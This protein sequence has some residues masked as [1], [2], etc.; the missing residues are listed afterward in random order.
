MEPM[1]D[2]EAPPRS[3]ARKP[4]SCSTCR[5]KKIRCD[6]RMPCCHCVKANLHCTFPAQ[7]KPRERKPHL[8]NRQPEEQDEAEA[9]G[10][11]LARRLRSLE[12]QVST[13][14]TQLVEANK[15]SSP[16]PRYELVKRTAAVHSAGAVSHIKSS[17]WASINFEVGLLPLLLST[18]HSYY[19]TLAGPSFPLQNQPDVSML[20]FKSF[21]GLRH[22]LHHPPETHIIL[23]WHVFEENV[24]PM[25]GLLHCPTMANL[26]ERALWSRHTL[27]IAE[28][29]LLFSMYYVA[30]ASM[31]EETI[32]R[33]FSVS[34]PALLSRMRVLVEQAL[35]AAKFASTVDV[36]AL[37]A[38]LLFVLVLRKTGEARSAGSLVGVIAHLAQCLRLHKD[39]AGM[40][41][42][43][44]FQQEMRRRVFW[45]VVVL[46]HRSAEDLGTDPLFPEHMWNTPLPLNINDVDLTE[47]APVLPTER[48]GMTDMTFFLIRVHTL[49]TSVRIR[50]LA[51]EEPGQTLESLDQR[52]EDMWQETHN[53]LE[54]KFVDPNPSHELAWAAK[55]MASC[56]ISKMKLTDQCSFYAPQDAHI[57][58]ASM[59]ARSTAH[60]ASA[61]RVMEQNH[62]ANL[63]HRW[64]KWKWIFVAYSRWHGSAILFK[65]MLRRPWTPVSEQGWVTLHKIMGDSKLG[66]LECRR[67]QP[68]MPLPFGFIYELTRH[69]RES[70]Y[71]RLCS[72]PDEARRLCDEEAVRDPSGAG[73]DRSGVSAS[74]LQ[75]W[76][77]A[78]GLLGDSSA[79]GPREE[80]IACLPGEGQMAGLADGLAM[81]EMSSHTLFSTAAPGY[82]AGIDPW[83]L[84]LQ[85]VSC[86]LLMIQYLRHF[87]VP[88]YQRLRD[89]LTDGRAA[90]SD[91]TAA[92]AVK[93]LAPSRAF[94]VSAPPAR[95]ALA[96]L[97]PS[98]VIGLVS[99]RSYGF[100]LSLGQRINHGLPT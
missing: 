69:Y 70:E 16:P 87:G 55:K 22:P 68:V 50:R 4:L 78:A 43:T 28:H 25:V 81:P 10:D 12:A 6:K 71:A 19:S 44:P 11:A 48:T 15:D 76:Q 53:M 46:D 3:Y 38:V 36:T 8:R 94:A 100:L 98:G 49:Q 90:T 92:L 29:A 7:R 41:D 13:L 67:D 61:I 88:C 42:L 84:N 37:Q 64:A 52:C 33:E 66:E 85:S 2:V 59:K 47:S 17:F 18:G 56:I 54:Q 24:E 34:K 73:A 75:R 39:G 14:Q 79:Q 40:Y 77:R 97:V 45:C 26:V 35:V 74:S 30:T 63:D 62:S 65:E 91:P 27:S 95:H 21:Q 72:Q 23:L 20:L 31:G 60:R 9:H 86:Q 93:D 5:I 99:I 51:S 58:T 32:I 83:P 89:S 57:M 1:A 96:I 82:D 80:L